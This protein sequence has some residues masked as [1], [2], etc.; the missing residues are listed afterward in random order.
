MEFICK[1]IEK[2]K[3]G[4]IKYDGLVALQEI[5]FQNFFKDM[6]ILSSFHSDINAKDIYVLKEEKDEEEADQIRWLQV[7]NDGYYMYS[8]RP[9]YI[10]ETEKIKYENMEQIN[11]Y[12]ILQL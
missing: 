1:I 7:E 4:L 12:Y 11:K 10:P 9:G 3:N 6:E 2:A 5:S 8:F